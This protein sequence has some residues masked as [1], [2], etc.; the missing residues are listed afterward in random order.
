MKVGQR[1]KILYEIAQKLNS[2]LSPD[3]ILYTVVETLCN[4]AKTK[5]C[6]LM[7]LSPDRK[8]LMHTIAYGLSDWYV[9]KGP[10]VVDDNIA[11]ALAGKP[12]AVLDATTDQRVQYREQAKREGIVSMLSLPIMRQG[13]IIGIIRMYTSEPRNFSARERKNRWQVR[14]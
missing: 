7:L 6:S 11:K 4:A 10:V 13:A 2:G 9:R 1:Y 12:M 5:G 3:E 8:Q 14:N